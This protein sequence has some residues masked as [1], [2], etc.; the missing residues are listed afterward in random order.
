MLTV[1]QPPPGFLVF[2]SASFG[3]QAVEKLGIFDTGRNSLFTDVLRSELQ[4]PGQSLVELADRVKLMARS[5][6]NANGIQQEPEYFY[7][8]TN[9]EDFYLVGSI[10]P[11]RLHIA[12]D[13]C[14]GE[15]A[16]C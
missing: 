15:I 4:P 3:E 12:Q 16:H 6:A 14:A 11:G 13:Q 10:G 1:R 2:Y 8:A 9:V 7:N 5:I